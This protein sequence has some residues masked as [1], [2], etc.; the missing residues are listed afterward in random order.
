[1]AKRIVFLSFMGLVYLAFLVISDFVN[2]DELYQT[3]WLGPVVLILAIIFVQACYDNKQENAGTVKIRKKE[4][5]G[6]DIKL[7]LDLTPEELE[8]ESL[9]Y[10]RI[11]VK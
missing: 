2:G 6:R 3:L 10:F 11:D 1:M 8:Q 4:T 9:I 7:E 5:G